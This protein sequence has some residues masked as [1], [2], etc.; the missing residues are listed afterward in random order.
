MHNLFLSSLLHQ[1]MIIKFRILENLLCVR[2][3][4]EL[5]VSILVIR[6]FVIPV[7][8]LC[9][10]AGLNRGIE[11]HPTEDAMSASHHGERWTAMSG[12]IRRTQVT[13]Y[14]IRMC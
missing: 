2:Q 5:L 4:G 14:C 13:G 6:P 9:H 3:C 10:T 1:R 11:S 12:R 8:V 7:C